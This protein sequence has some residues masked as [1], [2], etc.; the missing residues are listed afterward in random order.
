[1][2]GSM[3]DIE[4]DA[5]KRAAAGES[6]GAFVTLDINRLD[7]H[8]LIALGMREALAKYLPIFM[9]RAEWDA[10]KPMQRM[11]V[12]DALMPLIRAMQEDLDKITEDLSRSAIRRKVGTLQEIPGVKT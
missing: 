7:K 11:V 10:S 3:S 5:A 2:G 8:E 6:L 1:M 12:Q 4:K 9:K